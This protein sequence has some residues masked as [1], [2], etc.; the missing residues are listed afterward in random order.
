MAA[1]DLQRRTLKRVM[2]RAHAR[3]EISQTHAK[4]AL[5]KLA[6]IRLAF[7][8]ALDEAVFD[9]HATIRE[10]GEASI[11]TVTV[12]PPA[13]TPR[14]KK[15]GKPSSEKSPPSSGV[16]PPLTVVEEARSPADRVARRRAGKDAA[17]ND[18]TE[19]PLLR[20]TAR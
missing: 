12:E 6:A 9:I 11:D 17:A 8:A 15:R 5:E 4:A 1:A 18:D 3:V 13:K 2:D 19:L 10:L 14:P 7:N 16:S 20:S